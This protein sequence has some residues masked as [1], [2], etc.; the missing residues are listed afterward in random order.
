[1]ELNTTEKYR[2]TILSLK[3]FEM[4]DDVDSVVRIIK[5]RPFESARD[6]IGMSNKVYD[7]CEDC[8][9]LEAEIRRLKEMY[10]GDDLK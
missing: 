10:E 1:M 6:M 9:T 4:R 7:L 3:K 8:E 2:K 5:S